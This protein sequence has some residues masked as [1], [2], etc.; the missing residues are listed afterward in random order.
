[1]VI[2][3]LVVALGAFLMCGGILAA[4]LL[5]AVQAAREAARRIECSNN[6]KQLSIAMMNYE[7]VHR[8]FPPAYIPD[9]YGRPMHSWRVLI[10]P[11]MEQESLYNKYHFDEP[12]DSPNNRALADQMPDLYACP[13]HA[14]P[15]SSET[16]YVMI[17]GPGTLSDGPTAS[18]LGDV[19][20]GLSNT[21]ML[22]EAVQ[23]GINWL[24]P[25]DLDARQISYQINSPDESTGI[26]SDHPGGVNALICDGAVRFL[27][28]TTDPET[29]KAL[30]TI[31]GGEVLDPFFSDF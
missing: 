19:R 16:S 25:R 20:D 27:E 1:M 6:L 23:S 3:I 10:L 28:D 14:G 29:V 21:I 8:C 30:S 2:V 5:P 26:Q 17:V 24:E 9:E 18:R 7:A 12:W 13:S 4:L 22:V 31:D 15:G 11:Y